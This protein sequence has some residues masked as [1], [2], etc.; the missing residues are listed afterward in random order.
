MDN[1]FDFG[2]IWLSEV[3]VQKFEGVGEQEGLGYAVDNVKIAVV[4]QSGSDVEAL[5]AAE[6]PG[7]LDVRIVVN[8]YWEDYGS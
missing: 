2:E 6:V 3:H 7:F 5:V 1:M 4:I 8:D